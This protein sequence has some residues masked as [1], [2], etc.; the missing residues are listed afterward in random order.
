MIYPAGSE[1][2]AMVAAEQKLA[3]EQAAPVVETPA[4]P[5]FVDPEDTA[6]GLPE[7]A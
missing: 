7:A 5:G 4:E 3:E 6:P 2:A 1:G